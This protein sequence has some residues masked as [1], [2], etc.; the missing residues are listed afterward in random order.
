MTRLIAFNEAFGVPSQVTDRRGAGRS[1][2]AP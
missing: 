2:V 1:R